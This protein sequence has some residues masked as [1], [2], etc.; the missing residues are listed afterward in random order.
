MDVNGCCELSE[1]VF[2][3]EV[4]LFWVIECVEILDGDVVF[5]VVLYFVRRR[6]GGVGIEE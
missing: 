4:L 5:D 3:C 1:W 6:F 2:W